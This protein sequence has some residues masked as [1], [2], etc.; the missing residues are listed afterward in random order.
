MP[1]TLLASVTKVVRCAVYITGN[2][3]RSD[4]GYAH[5]IPMVMLVGQIL[6]K[7]PTIPYG[8]SNP[9]DREF[10]PL[11]ECSGLDPGSMGKPLRIHLNHTY[12]NPLESIFLY[13]V[14]VMICTPGSVVFW[15]L[16]DD[17]LACAK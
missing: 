16:F 9:A 17:F 7:A 2:V 3:G 11:L 15:S 8:R 4:I 12:S 1:D 13:G 6:P 14:Y 5:M 10:S